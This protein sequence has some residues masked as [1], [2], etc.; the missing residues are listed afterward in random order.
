MEKSHTQLEETKFW[1]TRGL[2]KR[3]DE[4]LWDLINRLEEQKQLE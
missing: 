2:Y 1:E 4:Q 3:G